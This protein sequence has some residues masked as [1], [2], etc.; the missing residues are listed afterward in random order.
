MRKQT[1]IKGSLGPKQTSRIKQ[2][3]FAGTLFLL[4]KQIFC[5]RSLTWDFS[6]IWKKITMDYGTI[7]LLMLT[8][9][10]WLKFQVLGWCEQNPDPSKLHKNL[11]QKWSF[12]LLRK[13]EIK[14]ILRIS[15]AHL[16][17]SQTVQPYNCI[18]LLVVWKNGEVG[19]KVTWFLSDTSVRTHLASPQKPSRIIR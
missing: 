15:L 17:M 2:I 6:I 5:S 10:M 7:N 14:F 11:T 9:F 12:H 3:W 13:N 16:K 4:H 1:I 18:K 8:T 19:A